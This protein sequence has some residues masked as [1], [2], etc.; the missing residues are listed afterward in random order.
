[1]NL[2][3][4]LAK[5]GWPDRSYQLAEEAAWQAARSRVAVEAQTLGEEAAAPYFEEKEE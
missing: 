1:L 4:W 2:R 3:S 5:S